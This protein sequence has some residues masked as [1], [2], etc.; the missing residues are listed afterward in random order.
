MPHGAPMPHVA[1]YFMCPM[2]VDVLCPCAGVSRKGVWTGGRAP[3]PVL[4]CSSFFESWEG[5]ARCPDPGHFVMPNALL[6]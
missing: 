6:C 2:M 4:L 3:V 1:S 5:A